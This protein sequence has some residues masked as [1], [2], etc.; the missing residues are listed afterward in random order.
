MIASALL[1]RVHQPIEQMDDAGPSGSADRNRIA[2]QVGLGD[3]G[4]YTVLFMADVDELDL[5]VAAQ[6]VNDG[7]ESVSNDAVAAF[8]S[9]IREHLPQ[10]VCYF[11]RHRNLRSETK[12]WL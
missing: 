5:A 3:G 1:A 7:I 10:D 8:D 2:G 11:S 9:R 12:F 6:P 4:E